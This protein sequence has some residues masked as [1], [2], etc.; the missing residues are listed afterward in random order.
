M[1]PTLDMEHGDQGAAAKSQ[2]EIVREVLGLQPMISPSE[3]EKAKCRKRLEALGLEEY[4]SPNLSLPPSP[5]PRAAVAKQEV[6]GSVGT[7][8]PLYASPVRSATLGKIPSRSVGTKETGPGGSEAT[9]HE[10]EDVEFSIGK[11]LPK[12]PK[13]K[14]TGRGAR[15]KDVPNTQGDKAS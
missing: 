12:D 2:N 9:G 13:S 14:T 1:L 11:Y 15:P 3:R 10:T 5:P 6:G 8:G 4:D 7:A